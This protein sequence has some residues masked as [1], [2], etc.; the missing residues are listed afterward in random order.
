MNN[1]LISPRTVLYSYMESIKHLLNHT[2]RLN[3]E[4]S[5]ASSISKAIASSILLQ[6]TRLGTSGHETPE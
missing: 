2:A 5:M 6:S 4:N 3:V 1:T